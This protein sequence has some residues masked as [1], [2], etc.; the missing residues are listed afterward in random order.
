MAGP[1]VVEL[2]PGWVLKVR[3]VEG[4]PVVAVRVVLRG[5]ARSEE[6]PGQALVAGRLL[7]EGTRRRDWRRLAEDVENRG[8]VLASSG[9]FEAHGLAVNALAADWRRAVEW[10]AEVVLEPAFPEARCAFLSRQAVAELES[11]ADQPDVRTGW[12]F[13]HQLYGEHPL[14]RPLQGNPE[15]LGRLMAADC[16]R[17]HHRGIA[18]G[19]AVTVAGSVEV[20]AVVEA[21]QRAFADLPRLLQEAPEPPAPPALDAGG[22]VNAPLTRR[23]VDLPTPD[24]AHLFVGHLTVPRGHPDAAG[25]GLLAVILGAGAGLTGRIPRRVREQEGLAYSTHAQTMS[26][27]GLDP[28]RLVAYAGIAPAAAE[29]AEV[30]LREE[31]ARLVNEGVTDDEVEEARAYLLGREPFRWETA[32]QWADAMAEAAFYRLPLDDPKWRRERLVGMDRG[33]LE[34]VAR[35]HLHPDRLRVTVG[36]PKGFPAG[37]G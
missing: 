10:A 26:G 30:V 7:A 21:A 32:R 3:P 28:G 33:R 12:A 5:G 6:V 19:G 37:D 36:L 22:I 4:P 14:G 15:S 16:A 27:A 11:L 17:F 18:G 35:R 1:E 23:R 2:A 29:R 31:I 9:T 25:L 8:M 13:L 24:Q 34:E 20:A